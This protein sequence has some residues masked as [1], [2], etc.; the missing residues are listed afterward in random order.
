MIT[1]RERFLMQQAMAAAEYYDCVKDWIDET[2]D[3]QGHTVA[4]FIN[5]E[6]DVWVLSQ[7]EKQQ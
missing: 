1:E 6:A 7:K 3:D 5:H 4:Q 2:I